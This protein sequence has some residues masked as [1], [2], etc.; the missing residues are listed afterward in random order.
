MNVDTME[1]VGTI[2]VGQTAVNVDIGVRK[3]V[4]L[5]VELDYTGAAAGTVVAIQQLAGGAARQET[6]FTVTGNTNIKKRP[7]VAVVNELG[8][9]GGPEW[10]AFID[11]AGPIRM[12]VSSS[13]AGA[14]IKARVTYEG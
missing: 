14:V 5:S 9:A 12:A 3:G 8:S 13:T 4:I 10:N 2:P 6:L 11:F 1:F 7:R